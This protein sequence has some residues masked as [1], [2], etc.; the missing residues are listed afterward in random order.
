MKFD[1]EGSK[2]EYTDT[3]E[4]LDRAIENQIHDLKSYQSTKDS[5]YEENFLLKKNFN[6]NLKTGEKMDNQH[7]KY[8]EI[9][10]NAK[11]TYKLQKNLLRDMKDFDEASVMKYEHELD[12]KKILCSKLEYEVMNS[13]RDFMDMQRNLE[14]IKK[15][16]SQIE[17]QIKER[18]EKNEKFSREHKEKIR[19]YLRDYI[20]LHQIYKKLK[21]KDVDSI[22]TRYR[23]ES[24]KYEG[25]NTLVRKI[26]KIIY[27]F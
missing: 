3:I 6:E 8:L 14:N 17:S 12:K 9:E 26:K 7:Y 18:H 16:S 27:F 20:K 4:H 24:I 10:S 22:I 11:R 2:E 19:E 25:N 21:V 13:K 1:T 5:L 23:E 15:V